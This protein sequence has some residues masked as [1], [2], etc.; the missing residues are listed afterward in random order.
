LNILL[1]QKV[2]PST[3]CIRERTRVTNIF[4]EWGKQKNRN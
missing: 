3:R 4:T 1:N 2:L